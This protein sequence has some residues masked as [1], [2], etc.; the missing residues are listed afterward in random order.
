MPTMEVKRMM[1]DEKENGKSPKKEVASHSL[2]PEEMF[3]KMSTAERR[4][5][6]WLSSILEESSMC[7]VDEDHRIVVDF[8]NDAEL[9]FDIPGTIACHWNKEKLP[10]DE[11]D[12]PNLLISVR[13]KPHYTLF[14]GSGGEGLVC[15]HSKTAGMPITDHCA[16]FVLWVENGFFQMPRTIRAAIDRA[17]GFTQQFVRD[18]YSYAFSEVSRMR[19]REMFAY[20]ESFSTPPNKLTLDRAKLDIAKIMADPEKRG[21]LEC[22]PDEIDWEFIYGGDYYESKGGT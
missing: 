10:T 1:M 15:V 21:L 16:S 6:N 14:G 12:P 17:R 13:A 19:W 11:P 8:E 9:V 4:G 2:V 22:D 3:E 20:C 7:F 18:L 5:L